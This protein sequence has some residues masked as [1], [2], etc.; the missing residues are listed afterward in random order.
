MKSLF[1]DI[2]GIALIGVLMKAS[3]GKGWMNQCNKI[4]YLLK[5]VEN[6]IPVI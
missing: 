5:M 2:P 1:N 3:R 6:K 4:I